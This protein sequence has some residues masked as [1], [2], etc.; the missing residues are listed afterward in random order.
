MG[1]RKYYSSEEEDYWKEKVRRLQDELEDVLDRK[2]KKGRRDDKHKRAK[3]SHSRHRAY[4]RSGDRSRRSK[5]SYTRYYNRSYSRSISPAFRPARPASSESTC[6]S[7]DVK[8]IRSVENPQNSQQIVQI[9]NSLPEVGDS[10]PGNLPTIQ[11]TVVPRAQTDVNLTSTSNVVV[12]ETPLQTDELEAIGDKVIKSRELAPAAHSEVLDRFGLLEIIKKGLPI[13]ERKNL[14]G[15]FLLPSN[16][17]FLDPPKLNGSV[18]SSIQ[19]TILKR[20][21]R[22]IEKQSKVAM[23]LSGL[24]QICSLVLK[25]PVSEEKS[26]LLSTLTGVTRI[27]T[28]IQHDETCIRRNLLL[29]NVNASMRDTLLSTIPDEWL[30]GTDVE[31]KVKAAKAMALV[32]NALKPH[33]HQGQANVTPKNG[34]S[35]LRGSTT[36]N[37]QSSASG[38]HKNRSF[39]KNKSTSNSRAPRKSSSQPNPRFKKY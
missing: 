18:K 10:T 7:D 20:D 39:P 15:K 26:A 30:F 9:Q 16:C 17:L 35:L 12:A 4:S 14:A 23:G 31:E 22:I 1:K 27:V 11:T 19:D 2:I 13:D 33:P 36:T 34:K 3:G 38:G 37:H 8:S 25:L 29:K 28:D 5:R 21:T 32:T 6:S 24:M